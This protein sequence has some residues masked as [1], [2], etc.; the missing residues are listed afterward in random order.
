MKILFICPGGQTPMESPSEN[1]AKYINS[2]YDDIDVDF[3]SMAH[4]RPPSTAEGYDLVWGDM[5][6]GG[7]LPLSLKL[8]HNAS[9]PC[10]LHGEWIPPYRVENGWETEFNEPTQLQHKTSYLK[11]IEAMSQ[12]D[13]V[14]LALD[15]TPGGFEFIKDRFDVTFPN[16]FV[17]YPAC[18]K[19]TYHQTQRK[20]QIA[21]IARAHDRK[22]R[23]THTAEAI[24][25]SQTKP[26]FVLIGGSN[27]GYKDVNIQS[28]GAFNND[29]K[30]K[31]FAES[32]LAVQ[33]WSGIP[34]AEAIQ[35]FC[36]VISYDIPYMRELYGDALIWVEKD[37]PSA[38]S[39]AIDYWM[40]HDEERELFALKAYDLFI[41]S[42]L[43]VKLDQ[44]RAQLVVENIKKLF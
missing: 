32:K 39:E 5:D 15:S 3:F 23:V 35:Q 34:P 36:P 43:G 22:K 25:L 19:Y 18:K 21:T 12:A 44:Y 29:D 14:S 4:N 20:N 2:N 30:V 31:I 33:H 10:Y 17:R 8:A 27:I 13:L 24:H 16:R 7:V 40:T 28:L 37:N 6:G 42:H 38:L 9:I 41:N 26:D 1:L 11:N